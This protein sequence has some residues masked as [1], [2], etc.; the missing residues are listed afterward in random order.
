MRPALLEMSIFGLLN[1]YLGRGSFAASE[2]GS[3]ETPTLATCKNSNDCSS[4]SY[5][6]SESSSIVV[7][8]CAGGSCVCGSR[9]HYHPALD[10]ALSAAT[11][12]GTGR[13][14]LQ[15][16]DEGISALYTEPYWSNYVGVRIYNDAGNTPGVYA[17]IIGAAFA[18]VCILFGLRV[19]KTMVKEKVY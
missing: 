12:L 11:N 18:L 19:K 8:T 16:E 3:D 6:N 13:F 1:D 7:P 10:E 17:S 2:D 15:D 14:E 9:S 5:C 4:V